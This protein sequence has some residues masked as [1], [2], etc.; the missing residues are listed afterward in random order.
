MT[1]GH[2]AHLPAA[3]CRLPAVLAGTACPCLPLPPGQ[4][5][6][7]MALWRQ[8]AGAAYPCLFLPAGQVVMMMRLERQEGG[9]ASLPGYGVMM[10]RLWRHLPPQLL[11]EGPGDCGHEVSWAGQWDQS[12]PGP[13]VHQLGSKNIDTCSSLTFFLWPLPGQCKGPGDGD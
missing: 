6:M 4:V 11:A 7:M 3:A 5:V 8:E 9:A 2:S 1:V 10:M 13:S 12:V